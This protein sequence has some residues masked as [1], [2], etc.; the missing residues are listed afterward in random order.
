MSGNGTDLGHVVSMLQQLITT[1]TEQGRT[2]SELKKDVSELK[3][4]V[5]T[6]K[7]DV[8]E[9]KQDV[10]KLKQDVSGLKLDVSELKLDMSALRQ[11]VEH[12]HGSV[13]GHGFL[14]TDLDDRM[15]LVE[16]HL[17]IPPKRKPS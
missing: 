3:L 10:L 9:L 14:I 16:H 2:L 4:D 1:Q 11:T 5:S 8:S 12:Y 17:D 13:M 7:Q 6:L 15:R